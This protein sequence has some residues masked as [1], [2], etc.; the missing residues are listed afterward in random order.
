MIVG[1]VAI[2]FGTVILTDVT[3]L[4][5]TEKWVA[6]YDGPAREYDIVS[7]IAVDAA[8]NVY[9]TGRSG[10]LPQIYDYATV[11]YDTYGT[12]LWARIYNGPGNGFDRANDIAV[13]A[14]GNVYVTGRSDDNED[15]HLQSAYATVKY[16]TN[17]T[18]LW[19]KRYYGPGN[20]DDESSGIAVDA[21]GNV[22]VTGWSE[23]EGNT[24]DQSDYAT[25][26]YDTNG[27]ELWAKRYNG[28]GNG[29]DAAFDIAVDAAGNVY[30]TGWSDY[31][32]DHAYA[33][34]K[35]DTNGTELWAKRYYG[36]G[37][38]NDESRSI[39]VDAAGNVYVTGRSE[40]TSGN[41][42]HATV[43]YDTNG[44]ELWVGRYNGPGNGSDIAKDI[45][46]D[47]AGNVYVT[48]V[49]EGTSGIYDYATVKYDT[50][51]TEQWVR[52]YNGP[53][54]G[55]DGS[56]GIAVDAAGNVYVT[57]WSDS[58]GTNTNYDYATVKY[59]TNGTV[60][61]VERYNG[62][63][64]GSDESSDIAVDATGNVYVTGRGIGTS[65]K[66]DYVTIKYAQ[67]DRFWDRW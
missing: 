40:S 27:T 42:D 59:D 10:M 1:S 54:N 8:G 33:T 55:S 4:Q 24:P 7:A 61:W 30:V 39:A 63:G 16:D 25:V 52:R 53:A 38:G 64:N 62:P 51:G 45:A 41:H 21:A 22:Y 9:V 19:A 3:K 46:V 34:V 31:P 29:T 11:K 36:P 17:G 26:K 14:A 65:G 35:Y 56:N 18:E 60:L 6:S 5:V 28:P 44:T 15:N 2:Y 66:A 23:N 48:G 57:G 49:S 32:S 50:S 43:K 67:I 12:E 47:A 13:D 37:N 20:G 58:S